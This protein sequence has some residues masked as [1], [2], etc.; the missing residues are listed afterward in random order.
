MEKS[1][2]GPISKLVMVRLLNKEQR[3]YHRR[4]QHKRERNIQ[5]HH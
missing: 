3:Y 4:Y 2:L 1:L 5:Q